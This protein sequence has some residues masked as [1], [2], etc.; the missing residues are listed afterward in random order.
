M[1]NAKFSAIK[2]VVN[3]IGSFFGVKMTKFFL[4][5]Y[6]NKSMPFL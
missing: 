4:E 5:N 1:S 2:I 3:N 6:N